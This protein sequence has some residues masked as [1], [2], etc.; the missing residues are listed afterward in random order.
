MI[1]IDSDRR[2]LPGSLWSGFPPVFQISH[3]G[4]DYE[5]SGISVPWACRPCQVPS[6]RLRISV[7]NHT[8]RHEVLEPSQCIEQHGSGDWS[9]P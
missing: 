2:P 7:P 3:V 9:K 4:L 6:A 1:S 8:N 5:L